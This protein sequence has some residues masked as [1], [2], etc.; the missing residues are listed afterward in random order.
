MLTVENYLIPPAL[1]SFHHLYPNIEVSV[2]GL[3]TG[4]IMKNL[5]ENKLDI[6]IVFLPMNNNEL[7]TISLYKEDLALA[8]PNEHPL[9]VKDMVS[10]EVLRTTPSILLPESY[11]IRQLINKSCN[12]LGFLPRPIL[13]ITTMESLINMVVKGIGITILPRPYLECLNN[14]KIRIIPSLNSNLSREVGIIYRKDK[15]MST[16]THIFVEQLKAT[17]IDLNLVTGNS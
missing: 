6:G 4:D 1:L 12:E 17:T 7:E 3:S 11:F 2:L 13:E 8:V 5:L 15:Y 16:A 10:L 9:E 14:N